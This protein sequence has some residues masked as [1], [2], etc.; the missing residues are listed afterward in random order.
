MILSKPQPPQSSVSS[1]VK[2]EFYNPHRYFCED[3]NLYE[4]ICE[5]VQHDA[6]VNY[7]KPVYKYY[8]NLG[9]L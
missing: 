5:F 1:D 9:L 2:W 4:N 3:K 8:H 6:D 7:C